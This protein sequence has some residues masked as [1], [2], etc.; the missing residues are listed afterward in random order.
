MIWLLICLLIKNNPV[1]AELLIRI[2]KLN[3]SIA[4]IAQSYFAVP[5]KIR[6]NSKDYFIMKIPNKWELKQTEFNHPSDI[7]IQE[8]VNLQKT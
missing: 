1:A 2:R 6:I 3:I 8:F 5:K 4:F 7:G